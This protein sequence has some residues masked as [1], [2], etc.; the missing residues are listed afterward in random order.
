[1]RKYYRRRSIRRPTYRRRTAPYRRRKTFGKFRARVY[2]NRFRTEIPSCSYV[3]LKF[4]DEPQLSWGAGGS[5]SSF[6]YSLNSAFDPYIGLGGG[7][8]SGWAAWAGMYDRYLCYGAKFVVHVAA[9]ITS[10]IPLT[11]GLAA[12]H[13][14]EALPGPAALIDWL[15]ESPSY[16]IISRTITGA[17]ITNSEWAR[18]R[19]SKYYAV[20]RIQ[21]VKSINYEEDYSGPTTGDPAIEPPV[22]LVA[23]QSTLGTMTMVTT[24][25]ITYYVKFYQP[26]IGYNATA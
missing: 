5:S 15:R 19:F 1:M 8:C 10:G 21:G 22:Y 12:C 4:H 13:T 17:G 9:G 11:I 6:S 18:T 2:R 3:K 14:G 24:V 25:D 26:K 16:K 23:V 7:T 20:K